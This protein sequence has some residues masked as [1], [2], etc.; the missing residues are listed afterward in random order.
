M[1]GRNVYFLAFALLLCLPV[2]TFAQKPDDQK[3][4]L[5]IKN[6][7]KYHVTR[8]IEPGV[9]IRAAIGA[10]EQQVRNAPPEW[11]QGA[12]AYGRRYGFSVASN[13]L[14]NGL[15]FGLDAALHED[16]RFYRL[17]K[18]SIWKRTQS[19]VRQTAICRN[20]QGRRKIAVWR[21]GSAFGSSAISTAWR[22]NSEDQF[23]DFMIR[24]IVTL[25][26]DTGSNVFREFWPDIKK[27][28]RRK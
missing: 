12:A 26:I 6:K 4:P 22:P 27:R 15:A 24:G 18:D 25:A 23:S 17:G 7:L 28:L 2:S 3:A 13:A 20:D 14:R 11:G 19:A 16:P 1:R 21:V 10:A 8:T 5:S 9:L